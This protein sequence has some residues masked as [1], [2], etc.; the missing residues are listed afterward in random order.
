[1][2]VLQ[3]GNIS[4]YPGTVLAVTA[5]FSVLS[6]TIRAAQKILDN[7][8]ETDI[9]QLIDQLQKY[10]KEKL[11]LTASFHLERIRMQNEEQHASQDTMTKKLLK[12]G[13]KSL[14]RKI[15]TCVER[16]NEVLDELRC[17]LIDLN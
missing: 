10:E 5:S 9:S 3:S 12:D 16:I 6:D 1:M 7:R 14:E 8:K 15:N 17:S 11:N 2:A 13:V 4:S